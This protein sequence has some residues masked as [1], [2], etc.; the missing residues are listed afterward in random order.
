MIFRVADDLAQTVLGT[1][2]AWTA[3][4]LIRWIREHMPEGEVWTFWLY[5]YLGPHTVDGA[6]RAVEINRDLGGPLLGIRQIGDDMYGE[7]GR[8]GQDSTDADLR[9][10]V[11]RSN[12]FLQRFKGDQRD[13]MVRL[14][15]DRFDVDIDGTD[16]PE[17]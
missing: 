13:E 10:A 11:T 6:D 8:V 4:D 9:N 7:M 2:E 12:V 5:L 14:V 15:G 17:M 16:V 3:D 1:F